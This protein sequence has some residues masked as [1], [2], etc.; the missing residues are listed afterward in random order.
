MRV[1]AESPRARAAAILVL[2]LSGFS[3]TCSDDETEA[4]VI[5][6]HVCDAD[7]DHGSATDAETSDIVATD[8]AEL[9]LAADVHIAE[10]D[11]GDA[12]TP[13]GPADPIGVWTVSGVQSV[14]TCDDSGARRVTFRI[15]ESD[16]GL[17]V[18]LPNGAGQRFE[19]HET[20]RSA[21]AIT[22]AGEGEM[23]L[24]ESCVVGV[25]IE[26]VIAHEQ[27][28]AVIA[29]GTMALTATAITGCGDLTGCEIQSQFEGHRLSV[30]GSVSPD[31][32]YSI[33]SMDHILTTDE[34]ALVRGEYVGEYVVFGTVNKQ[35][36][37][38]LL[39]T[40][41]LIEF[42]AVAIDGLFDPEN[43]AIAPVFRDQGYLY[44]G[45]WEMNLDAEDI[46]EDVDGFNLVR[47]NN[48]ID[49][50]TITTAGL[51]ERGAPDSGHNAFPTSAQRFGD[52]LYLGVYNPATTPQVWRSTDGVSFDPVIVP[53][54]LPEGWS[55]CN[56]DITSMVLYGDALYFSTETVKGTCNEADRGTQIWRLSD[57]DTLDWELVTNHGFDLPS[58]ENSSFA[59]CH[60]HLYAATWNKT[61]GFELLRFGDDD[62]WTRVVTDGFG[63]P[64]NR[65]GNIGCMEITWN[66]TL[67]ISTTSTLGAELWVTAHGD[68]SATA[69]DWRLLNPPGFGLAHSGISTRFF[70]YDSF[71]VG[72][73]GPGEGVLDVIGA[74]RG[75]LFRLDCP[76]FEHGPGC[77]SDILDIELGYEL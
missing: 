14:N 63:Q 34:L 74:T 26:T 22:F 60:D 23:T 61:V 41:D 7:D 5:V 31:I 35:S 6:V 11:D 4:D 9:D 77:L 38:R 52:Y 53:D 18:Y 75:G 48:G 1:H 17:R 65:V 64:M 56:T 76:F 49:W 70:G 28:S 47:S 55:S 67:A 51:A 58:N 32:S 10:P 37:A 13:E 54:S 16:D 50:E 30:D 68:G 36:S 43:F 8:A 15:D 19:L 45:S 24:D 25:E 39:R 40:A 3:I 73:L 69:G 71:Y 33:E 29:R 21:H 72:T 46:F 27:Y 42:E 59:V 20:D 57:P 62:E 44:A 2:V 12:S 66:E